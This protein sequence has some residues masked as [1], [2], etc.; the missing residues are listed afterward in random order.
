MKG[1]QDKGGE[2]KGQGR[3]ESKTGEKIQRGRAI[4]GEMT[5][6]ER[7]E[8]KRVGESLCLQLR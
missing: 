4:A 2:R 7:R 6:Q 1:G 3:E 8:E 5:G